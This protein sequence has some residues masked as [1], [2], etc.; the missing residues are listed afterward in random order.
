MWEQFWHDA[1]R[2]LGTVYFGLAIVFVVTTIIRRR[3]DAQRKRRATY[4]L[5]DGG[6]N[7]VRVTLDAQLSAAEHRRILVEY[8]KVLDTYAPAF[9]PN[10]ALDVQPVR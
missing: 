9:N 2:N 10:S 3:L 5:S 7:S 6:L 1:V 8:G 4:V